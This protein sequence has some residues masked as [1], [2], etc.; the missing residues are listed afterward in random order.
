VRDLA[1]KG[2][3]AADMPPGYL[4]PPAE[5]GGEAAAPPG[6]A[7][8]AASVSA[9]G[10][11]AAPAVPQGFMPLPSAPRQPA[12]GAPGAAPAMPAVP[13]AGAAAAPALPPL[14]A[15]PSNL[16][17]YLAQV[18]RDI[19]LRALAQTQYNRTQAASLLGISFRQLR[20]QMQKLNI[21]E[22]ET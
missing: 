7:S 2:S 3:R 13:A 20:Y 12:V 19:I 16:P 21:Q 5:L 11:R 22:P 18:E 6:P 14:D 1:L 4:P 8:A 15:L 9:P 17:D 10:L